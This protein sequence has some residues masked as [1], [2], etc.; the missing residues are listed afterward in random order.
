MIVSIRPYQADDVLP[1]WDAALES[2]S[3]AFPFMPWC[4][5]D[6]TVEEQRIW[7]GAQVIAF[8]AGTAF[9]FAIVSDDGRYLGGCGLN[10]IDGVNRRA[11]LGYW[12]RSSSTGRGVA[13]NAVRQL[14]AWAFSHTDLVRLEVVV[15]TQNAVSLRV[16][17]KVGA[18]REGI[19]LSRLLLHGASHDAA[20]FSIVRA[21][22]ES[23]ALK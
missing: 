2:V 5:P 9:E 18:V 13:T 19:A 21:D 7:I 14:I 15:S 10:Q 11:N 4:R 8:E 22:Y 6:L 17:E 1:V 16:A 23:R 12:V 3:E 20:I